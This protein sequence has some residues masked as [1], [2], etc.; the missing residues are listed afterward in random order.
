M[1]LSCLLAGLLCGCTSWHTLDVSSGYEWDGEAY[2]VR[3]VETNGNSWLLSDFHVAADTLYGSGYEER[4]YED[5][6]LRTARGIEIA[7]PDI[8]TIEERKRETRD[9]ILLGGGIVAAGALT[10]IVLLP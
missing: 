2:R 8:A 4:L 1:L 7:L 3:V 9:E 10:L 5:R 6:M